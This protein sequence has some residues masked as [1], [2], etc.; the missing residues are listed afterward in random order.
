MRSV[1]IKLHPVTL[2][3]EIPKKLKKTFVDGDY[4][5]EVYYIRDK[6]YHAGYAKLKDGVVLDQNMLMDLEGFLYDKTTLKKVC[7]KKDTYVM[8]TF[9]SDEYE[10]S[11]EDYD[12]ETS[13]VLVL[14]CK[15]SWDKTYTIKAKRY[16]NNVTAVYEKVY[17]VEADTEEEA[18][19]K[20]LDLLE[21]DAVLEESELSHDGT[22]EDY[23]TVS[24]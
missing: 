9:H 12:E 14:F 15:H 2:T 22:Y 3:I 4:D 8:R 23:L 24:D 7:H 16:F 10:N 19:L 21:K 6:N 11:Y 18:K 5:Y 1:E 13:H 20:V 17:E